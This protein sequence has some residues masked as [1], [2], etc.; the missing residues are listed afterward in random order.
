ML[1][2]YQR[3]GCPWCQP[4]R[5]RLT[6]LGISYHNINVPKERTARAELIEATGGHFIPAVVD[7]EVVVPGELE[8]YDRVL[9]YVDEVYGSGDAAG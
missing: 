7:G 2:L 1:V 6:E 9:A 4:V 3:E 8:S 5:L